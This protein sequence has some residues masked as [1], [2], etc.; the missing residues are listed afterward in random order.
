MI[1]LNSVNLQY[2]TEQGPIDILRNVDLALPA[3]ERVAIA[4][5]SGS[6]KT[7]LLLLLAG[8]EAPTGGWVEFNGERLDALSRD[9][10]AD[11]RRDQIGI[12][13]QSFHLIP[14]LNALDNAALP[15]EIAGARDARSRVRKLL[16]K[17]GLG[18]RLTHYPRQL[19]GGEQQRVAIVRALA[20]RPSVLLADEPTGNLDAQTG[21]EV[22]SLLLELDAIAGT[23][24][25]LV[26]H[27]MALANRCDR[28]L[29]M[30]AGKLQEKVSDHV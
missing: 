3:G 23:T 5:P 13:F 12:V 24:L 8:L 21:A 25:V 29:T 30:S 20:H 6:G 16:E 17:V 7:S 11:M 26:T 28:V 10:L 27:D 18:H 1:T 2:Q 22:A 9:A 4:G 14:S 19:S 15:L